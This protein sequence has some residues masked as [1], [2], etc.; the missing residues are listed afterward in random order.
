VVGLVFVWLEE[1]EGMAEASAKG[2]VEA[3]EGRD[4]EDDVEGRR[5][6]D[7]GR[8]CDPAFLRWGL[9]VV[10]AKSG[11]V[12]RGPRRIMAWV[13]VDHVRDPWVGARSSLR[14]SQ[15]EGSGGR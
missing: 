6:A 2:A 12:R 1:G 11:G 14:V 7:Y 5:I 4:S 3:L 10:G 15:E 13:S 8:R 9:R